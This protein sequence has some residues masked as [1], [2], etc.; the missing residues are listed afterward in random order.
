MTALTVLT[1]RDML[2]LFVLVAGAPTSEKIIG[3]IYHNTSESVM[4]RDFGLARCE[5]VSCLPLPLSKHDIALR[6]GAVISEYTHIIVGYYDSLGTYLLA[7]VF[8]LEQSGVRTAA[9]LGL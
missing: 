2:G 6:Y 7:A 8:R 4:L 3:R 1:Q 9:L 5:D